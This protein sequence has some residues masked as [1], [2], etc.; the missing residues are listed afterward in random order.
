MKCYLHGWEKHMEGARSALHLDEGPAMVSIPW[1]NGPLW[2]MAR[3][4]SYTWTQREHQRHPALQPH[5]P[6]LLLAFP[7]QSHITLPGQSG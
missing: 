7:H 4:P 3:A 2:C 6:F 5:L 1:W